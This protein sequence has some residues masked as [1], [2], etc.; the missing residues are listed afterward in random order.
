MR[1]LDSKNPI[2]RLSQ[3]NRSKTKLHLKLLVVGVAVV[4]MDMP[5]IS[6]G[7]AAEKASETGLQIR[8]AS[9]A[10]SVREKI[11]QMIQSSRG[12]TNLSELE[13]YDSNPRTNS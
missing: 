13:I 4:L 7:V 3:R 11:E 1:T 5:V 8:A 12:T 9:D 2:C 6:D 10:G